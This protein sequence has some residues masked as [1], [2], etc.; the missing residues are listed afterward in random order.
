MITIDKLQNRIICA[1]CLDILRQLPDKCVDLVCTDCPYRVIGGGCATGAYGNDRQDMSKG[2]LFRGCGKRAKKWE[3]QGQL[4]QNYSNVKSGKMFEYNEIKFEEWLPEIYRVLK[5]GTHCY[6]M[7]NGR[8]LA[9][10]QTKAEKVGFVFQQLLVWDKG[11]ATPTK[12][13]LQCCE[14]IL[15]LRKGSAKYINDMGYKTLLSI[16]NIIGDKIHPTEKPI[17][18][19]EILIKNSTNKGDIVLDP[20][21]GS[22]PVAVASYYSERN[23]ICIEK[24]PEY[25]R[26]SCERLEQAQRQQILF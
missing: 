11:N 23:F 9:E 22:S 6:I 13:Y 10:L 8:N 1:D 3:T 7:I 15:M 20:F 12:W 25:Y 17:G 16:P 4:D 19:M 2:V 14:F 18:L 21:A 26:A 24:D 5:D